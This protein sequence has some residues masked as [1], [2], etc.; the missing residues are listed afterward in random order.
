MKAKEERLVNQPAYS[1]QQ[2]SST[3]DTRSPRQMLHRTTSSLQRIGHGFQEQ[4][5][6]T[7]GRAGLHQQRAIF[8]R[9]MCR[10]QVERSTKSPQVTRSDETTTT[11]LPLKKLAFAHTLWYTPITSYLIGM[12]PCATKLGNK[13]QHE[14]QTQTHRHTRAATANEVRRP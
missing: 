5:R 8:S 13:Y 6:R 11:E 9:Q 14:A 10:G 7:K 1:I 4:Q 12:K 3:N 2:P